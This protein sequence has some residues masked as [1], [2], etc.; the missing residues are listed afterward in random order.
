VLRSSAGLTGVENPPAVLR[1]VEYKLPF[2]ATLFRDEATRPPEL[3]EAPLSYQACYAGG[4]S[5]P[6]SSCRGS[7]TPVEF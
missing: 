6:G 1:N 7:E 5:P 3:A 2:L 4:A